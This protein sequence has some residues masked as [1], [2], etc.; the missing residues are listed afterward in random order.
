MYMIDEMC[1]HGPHGN[2][3][4][5]TMSLHQEAKAATTTTNI[6]F[7]SFPATI[8][9]E[10]R[11]AR[12]RF[13]APAKVTFDSQEISSPHL[14]DFPSLAWEDDPADMGYFPSMIIIQEEDYIAKRK[15]VL[16]DLTLTLHNLNQESTKRLLR[17]KCIMED[18]CLLGREEDP[19]YRTI[20][21]DLHASD[22]QVSIDKRTR[23]SPRSTVEAYPGIE[24]ALRLP[25]FGDEVEDD[26]QVM[27]VA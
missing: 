26:L 15:K 11:L 9:L 27:L 8:A 19:V 24:N 22:D 17:S 18:L 13:F 4:A 21:L 5:K 3:L 14:E 10:K 20:K 2:K 6:N 12:D 23:L 25:F 16:R 1:K 7:C